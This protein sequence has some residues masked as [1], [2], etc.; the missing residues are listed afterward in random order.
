MRIE[1]FA[2]KIMVLS[3]S[4]LTF[5]GFINAVSFDSDA[6]F[7]QNRAKTIELDQGESTTVEVEWTNTNDVCSETFGWAMEI[8]PP[9]AETTPNE[10]MH[11][12]GKYEAGE[13]DSDIFTVSAPSSG[14]GTKEFRVDIR[15][16]EDSTWPCDGE[17]EIDQYEFAINYG[18]SELKKTADSEISTAEDLINEAQGVV[19]EAQSKINEAQNM[20]A[21]VTE[22]QSYLD[23]AQSDIDTANTYLSNA[24]SAYD[25]SNYQSAI[26]YAQDAQSG[27]KSAKDHANSAKSEA[28]QAID[29]YE[30]GKSEAENK[31]SSGRSAISTAKDVMEKA[32]KITNDAKNIGL[33]TADE[34]GDIA[35]ARSNIEAAQNYLQE[36]NNAFDQGDYNEAKNKADNAIDKAESAQRLANNA[37]NSLETTVAKAREA[38]DAIG[39]AS[40]KISRINRIADDLGFILDNV[41]DKDIQLPE[42]TSLVEDMN[43]RITQ[44]EDLLSE[45]KNYK[46]SGSFSTAAQK[47]IAAKNKVDEPLNRLDTISETIKEEIESGL[48]D[49]IQNAEAKVDEAKS[50]V[51][52]AQNSYGADSEKVVEAQESLSA[53]EANLKEAKSNF[54][55]F[56]SE[57]KIDN[58]VKTAKD[59]TSLLSNVEDSITKAESNA[60][61]AIDSFYT[62]AAGAAAAVAGA[63]GGGFLYWKRRKKGEKDSSEEKSSNS[64][65]EDLEESGEENEESEERSKYCS[66]CGTEVDEDAQYCPE[67]GQN[68]DDNSS[69]SDENEGEGYDQKLEKIIDKVERE[70]E[71]QDEISNSDKI[72]ND[73]DQAEKL[74]DEK[75]YKKAFRLYKEIY[76]S[77]S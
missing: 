62:K 50:K 12:P 19:S 6:Y 59:S 4:F 9:D 77:L 34:E 70:L 74:I 8:L 53:A 44:A 33:E 49:K 20:G 58:L 7:T 32:E 52:E 48:N 42:S 43:S 24:K 21:S 31:I 60:Q 5:I 17:T 23:K 38:S 72:N 57:N 22:A 29:E 16:D 10:E 45:A 67:C 35:E 46:E 56:Q 18:P 15:A 68:L 75:N 54:E 14:E 26:N 2:L 36:A 65:D 11:W 30:E 3:I 64:N 63:A 13:G 71:K 76:E 37:Y 28:Q 61:S 41:K 40:D 25:S 39:D 69:P 55:K 1:N 47:A 51:Q 27:A 73:I 66:K